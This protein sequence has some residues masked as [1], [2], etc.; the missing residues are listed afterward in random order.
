MKTKKNKKNLGNSLQKNKKEVAP[1][2]QGGRMVNYTSREERSDDQAPLSH[3]G[4][5]N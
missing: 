5:T 1:L 4:R 2:S 3:E